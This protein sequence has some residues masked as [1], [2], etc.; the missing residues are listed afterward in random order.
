MC[1]SGVFAVFAC[2]GWQD[3][4]SH[5]IKLGSLVRS[6]FKKTRVSNFQ[7]SQGSCGSWMLCLVQ[8]KS[9]SGHWQCAQRK[10]ACLPLRSRDSA[11]VVTTIF[12]PLDL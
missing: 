1:C 7:L 2:V 3:V 9:S 8:I 10:Q 11:I 4:V 6:E 12:E 5:G